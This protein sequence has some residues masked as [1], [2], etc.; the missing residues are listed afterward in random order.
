MPKGS[1][2]SEEAKRKIADARRGA[3][4]S[5]ET[6]A[7]LSAIHIG[8]PKWVTRPHPR[9]TLGKT[10]WNKGRGLETKACVQCEVL[11]TAPVYQKRRFCSSVCSARFHSGKN[12]HLYKGGLPRKARRVFD[13]TQREAKRRANGGSHTFEQW[14]QLCESFDLRCVRCWRRVPE[15]VLTEDHV[16]PVSKGGTNDISNIQP[17]CRSC[18]SIKSTSLIDFRPLAAL[19]QEWRQMI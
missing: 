15:I 8:R 10:A 1:H 16:L 2:Q 6:K 18:N 19:K 11:F 17:L 14:I 12:S 5:P 9:G 7:K 4:L 13:Q 3:H